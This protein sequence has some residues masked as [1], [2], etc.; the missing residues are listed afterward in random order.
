MLL[1]LPSGAP[2]A[3][4]AP[5]LF[6]CFIDGLFAHAAPLETPSVR[7]APE[8]LRQLRGKRG[9]ASCLAGQQIALYVA[10]PHVL[11]IKV[12][13]QYARS[14]MLLVILKPLG[15]GS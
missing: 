7:R 3:P 15:A 8:S 14:V 4:S 12:T 6:V 10:S 13:R 11:A 2:G 5:R 9:S 1:R